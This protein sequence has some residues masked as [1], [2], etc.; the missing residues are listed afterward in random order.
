MKKPKTPS[1]RRLRAAARG[2]L[3]RKTSITVEAAGRI[4]GIGR[5][6][7]YAGVRSGE[8]PSIKIG[9]RIIVP[10]APIRKM[11]GLDDD[12]RA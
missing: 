2:A 7:A 1:R 12:R 3:A 4:L 11:L 9:G 6:L 10:V 8:I 5:S